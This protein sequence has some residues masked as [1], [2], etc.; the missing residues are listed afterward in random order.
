MHDAVMMGKVSHAIV[1]DVGDDKVFCEEIRKEKIRNNKEKK[2]PYG[3]Y[4]CWG[5]QGS[6]NIRVALVCL[7][8]ALDD[9]LFIYEYVYAFVKHVRDVC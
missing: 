6:I 5:L 9:E 2:C 7:N 1:D 4:T 3:A 8:T